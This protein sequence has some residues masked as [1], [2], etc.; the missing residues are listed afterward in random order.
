M[1][2]T[3]RPLAVLALAAVIAFLS[4]CGSATPSNSSSSTTTQRVKAEQF[5]QCMRKNGVSGFPDPDASGSLTIDQVANGS[6]IDTSSA[7][8]TQAISACKSLEPAGFTGTARTPQQMTVAREWAR[9]IRAHGVS[10]FPDPGTTGP[11]IDTKR[12]PSM[13]TSS[14]LSILHAAMQQCNQYS[15]G[16]GLKK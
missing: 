6:S 5:S 4:A 15:A 7:S 13:A 3:H 1:S 10:D 14:G 9:C 8:F 12:I 16:M 11:L 2:R